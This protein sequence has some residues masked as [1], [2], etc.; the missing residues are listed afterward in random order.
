VSTDDRCL[1]PAD[2]ASTRDTLTVL[3]HGAIDTAHA[4]V[5]VNDGERLLFRQWFA[6]PLRLD[7]EG[8]PRPAVAEAW[9]RDSSG[10]TWT[11]L[12]A[13]HAGVSAGELASAWQSRPGAVAALRWAGMETVTPL[14]PSRLVVTFGAAQ[15]SVPAVF[16]DPALSIRLPGDPRPVL[17]PFPT[18]GSDL[19]DALDRGVDLVPTDDPTLL[20]YAGRRPELTTAALPWTRTYGLVLS[21]TRPPLL[22]SSM[23]DS[24]AFRDA[25]ARDAVPVSARGAEPPY[26]WEDSARCGITGSGKPPSHEAPEE[27]VVYP[28][29]DPVG[30]ALAERIVA[31]TH[32][33]RIRARGLD[34]G[35]L[36][37]A[38]HAGSPRGVIL[39]L[40]R[41]P[42]APC[43]EMAGWA[44]GGHLVP[45]VDVR[46]TLI[47][48]RELPPLTVD[49]D[50]AVRGV[51]RSP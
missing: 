25:L 7:C 6:A 35:E 10:K 17:V 4:P 12:L 49:W 37:D 47:L 33:S 15:D 9:T 26:W 42:L 22:P 34:A 44:G 1:L 19:R 13:E 29:D 24:S 27:T 39:A 11:L 20:E 2:S 38:L 41:N 14:H 50:G 23:T 28:Q 40:P 16:A 51:G 21:P 31:L 3:L 45:L 36:A 46:A 18:A 48:R 5:P 30:R 8:R 32:D 43:R